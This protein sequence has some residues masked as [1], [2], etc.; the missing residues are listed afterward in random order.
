MKVPTPSRPVDVRSVAITGL[1]TMAWY[2]VPDV[3]GPR[4]GRAL[5]K[6]GVLAGG[7][8]LGVAATSEGRSALDGVRQ[9]RDELRDLRAADDAG[10]AGEPGSPTGTA[11]DGG[12]RDD[13]VL[14][15]GAL[16]GA[17]PVPDPVV[18]GAAAAGVVALATTVA[19]L[20]EKWAYRRGERWRQRGVRLPHTRVGLVLGVLAAAATA[21]DP[22]I[23][24]RAADR[25]EATRTASS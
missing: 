6:V 11:A 21:V 10:D 20:G 9:V 2:A 13:N 8:A 1:T 7:V 12:D 16:A 5:A 19:V 23:G 15:D 14:A 25:D 4:W 18:A 22:T 3:V 17:D 24:L